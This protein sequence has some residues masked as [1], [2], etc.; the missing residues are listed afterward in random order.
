MVLHSEG[1]SVPVRSGWV[2]ALN[3]SGFEAAF[4]MPGRKSA[5][6]AFRDFEPDVF[7]GTTYD[8]DS[9]QEKCLRAR[10][11]LRVALFASAWGPLADALP[12]QEFPI[13]RVTDGEKR[14][15]ERLKRETGK[16]DCV[17][18]HASEANLEGVLGGW[19]SIGIEPVSC[20]NGADLALYRPV[21][22]RPELMCDAAFVGGR[23]SFKARNL[24]PFLLPLCE[25]GFGLDVKV[26]GY[27][28]WQNTTPNYLG[29]LSPEEEVAL[30]SSAKVCLNISEPHSVDSR[31]A[32]DCV[33]RLFKTAACGAC[34]VSDYVEE[35][36]EVFEGQLV[37]ARTPREYED[38]LRFYVDEEYMARGVGNRLR[39]VVLRK[40]T[41]FHRVATI[42]N[43]VGLPEEA[44]QCLRTLQKVIPGISSPPR[45]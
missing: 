7:I 41:Y 14:R 6:D 13:V 29:R 2:R 38:V 20:L 15:L 24:D 8:L 31:Y 1:G 11:G 43:A 17:F 22:P 16:P 23:W 34:V 19:R 3:A 5:F 30:Y 25:P 12:A 32:S 45:T 21:R 18:I 26:F 39:E 27:G 40:H 33:E 42:L 28:G 37:M 9:A 35:A 36:Q 44:S 4:W 10:P